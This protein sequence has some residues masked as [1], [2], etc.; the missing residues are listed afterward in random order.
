[1]KGDLKMQSSGTAPKKELARKLLMDIHSSRSAFW[2]LLMIVCAA[3]FVG[4]SAK[5]AQ[6]DLSYPSVDAKL[7]QKL[8]DGR[9]Q[10]SIGDT[11][12]I[13]VREMGDPDFKSTSP[14]GKERWTYAGGRLAI[15][16]EN[17]KVID[18]P[19]FAEKR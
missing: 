18:K 13:V 6:S 11:P 4:C 19:V 15:D 8:L 3:F 5:P 12:D 9:E 1:M 2:P 7:M 17:S 14:D 10:V 16:F